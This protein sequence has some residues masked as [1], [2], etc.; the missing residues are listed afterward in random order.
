MARTYYYSVQAAR[1]SYGYLGLSGGT[2]PSVL[3][4]VILL[5]ICSTP[6]V[7]AGGKRMALVMGNS[8]YR[9]APLPNALNDGRDMAE[10]LRA[11]GFT[12][13]AGEN[14]ERRAMEDAIITFGEHLQEEDVGL[15]YFAGHGVQ[16]SGVNYLIPIQ[17]Q[18]TKEQHIS[19]E[20]VSLTRVLQVMEQAGNK[21]NIVI[22]DACRN[23][24]FI[25]SFRSATRGLA[26]V[27]APKG[28]LIAYATDPGDVAADGNGRNGLY[29]EA[30]LQ[31]IRSPDVEILEVFKG[32]GR[33][34]IG[35]SEGKQVPWVNTSVYEDFY[36]T[37]SSPASP[38]NLPG[39]RQRIAP[40]E[41]PTPPL[42]SPPVSQPQRTS[43]SPG[44]F[45]IIYWVIEPKTGQ[46]VPQSHPPEQRTGGSSKPQR[47]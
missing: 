43:P 45:E 6:S 38:G 31:H 37:R 3:L 41:T 44:E 13:I 33:A 2:L 36:F 5:A 19:S 17:A 35:K 23:N 7:S 29:T 14:L 1:G 16:V 4:T 30:L 15:F 46:L 22:L 26:P 40:Q 47:K 11:V 24:P 34:V 10:A 8:T 9:E 32:V 20:A 27:L 25:G 42:A 18:I 39:G 12:V 21:T 28:M